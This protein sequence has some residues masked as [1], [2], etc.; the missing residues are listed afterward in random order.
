LKRRP[1]LFAAVLL[2]TVL[3]L[4]SVVSIGAA[5]TAPLQG[6]ATNPQIDRALPVAG[7]VD[8]TNV[9]AAAGTFS[10][11]FDGVVA[12]QRVSDVPIVGTFQQNG[13]VCTVL[14]LTLGPL[15]LNLLG[16]R[17]QLNQIHLLITA[18]RGEGLLG[19]LLCGLAGG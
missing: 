19:D 17:I 2:A 6:S 14:D 1:R 9:D 8:V 3:G 16:L 4:L 10:G 12:G 18:R 13:G 5:Q 7:T 15:D 11:T